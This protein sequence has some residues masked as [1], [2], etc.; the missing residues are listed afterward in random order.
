MTDIVYEDRKKFFDEGCPFCKSKSFLEG[1]HGGLSINFKCANPECGAVFNDMGLFG[2][3][4][5]EEPIRP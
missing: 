2:V 5:I 3:E 4:L 1:P